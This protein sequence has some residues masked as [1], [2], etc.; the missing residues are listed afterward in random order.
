MF[1]V[2]N[3]PF[4]CALLL[5]PVGSPVDILGLPVTFTCTVT[6]S[7]PRVREGAA[8][9]AFTPSWRETSFLTEDFIYRVPCGVSCGQGEDEGEEG[10]REERVRGEEDAH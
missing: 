5:S 4:S 7:S 6:Y 1:T 8:H 2:S 9:P 3:G 10:R